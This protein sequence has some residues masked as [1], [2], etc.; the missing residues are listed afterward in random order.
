MDCLAAT[1]GQTVRVMVYN[2]KNT[3]NYKRAVDFALR[4]Q[5]P[6][7]GNGRVQIKTYLINDDCNFFDDWVKDREELGITNSAFGWSPDDPLLDT[8]VTLQSGSARQKYNNL[9]SKY[10]IRA[11]LLPDTT[12]DNLQDGVLILDERLEGSNVVFLEIQPV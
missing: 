9:K 6:W 10:T 8:S 5:T 4:V 2:F 12:F 7:S 1:D 11:R 3:L